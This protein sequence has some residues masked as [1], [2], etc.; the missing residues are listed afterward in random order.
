MNGL[1]MIP[2]IA[3]YVAVRYDAAVAKAEARDLPPLRVQRE[4]E[5]TE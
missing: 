2:L 5:A 1:A 3:V 4:S